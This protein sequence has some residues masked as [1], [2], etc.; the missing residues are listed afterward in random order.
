M[1]K[2]HNSLGQDDTTIKVSDSDDNYLE[3]MSG[4]EL[5]AR[6]SKQ[7]ICTICGLSARTTEELQDH[8]S[9]AHRE[10]SR[11]K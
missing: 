3:S 9:N 4:R 2:D 10:A 7:T 1:S 5:D 6:E 8:V 11:K